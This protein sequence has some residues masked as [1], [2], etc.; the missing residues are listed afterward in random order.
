MRISDGLLKPVENF[1]LRIEQIYRS[2]L[3]GGRARRDYLVML[4]DI[5]NFAI[6]LRELVRRA[7]CLEK[8]YEG[9]RG[10]RIC[11]RWF[12][13]ETDGWVTLAKLEPRI[14]IS[15][16]SSGVIRVSY[17]PVSIEVNGTVITM[18][19]N[20]AVFKVDVRSEDDV[21]DKR[22]IIINTVASLKSVL[23]HHRTDF[24]L[25]AREHRIPCPAP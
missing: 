4:S 23:E 18:R 20:N 11:H 12:Y 10:G 5:L 1:R 3:R 25:C 24:E 16:E 14:A 7:Q 15:A 6:L 19:L 21:L 8:L 2:A 22:G 13:S 17:G 9:V